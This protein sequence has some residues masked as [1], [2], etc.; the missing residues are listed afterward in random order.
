MKGKR[1]KELRRSSALDLLQTQLKRGTKPE[2]IDGKTT[3]NMVPLTE[4][5]VK[6]IK[7]EIELL[8]HPKKK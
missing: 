1:G 2:K 8:T 6:R 7:R 4:G 5:D 3:S